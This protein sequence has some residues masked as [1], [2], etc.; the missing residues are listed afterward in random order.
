[1]TPFSICED[2]N[3]R[4]WV[5]ENNLLNPNILLMMIDIVN[6]ERIDRNEK[7]WREKMVPVGLRWIEDLHRI[8]NNETPI[9]IDD[10]EISIKFINK[11]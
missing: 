6:I 7:F 11:K 5:D 8:K 1:M 4:K 3:F 2:K 10:L 9:G